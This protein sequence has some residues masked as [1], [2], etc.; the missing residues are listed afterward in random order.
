VGWFLIWKIWQLSDRRVFTE[1]LPE[2]Q[3]L[4]LG[5]GGRRRGE[6]KMWETTGRIPGF[7]QELRPK[8]CVTRWA[9]SPPHTESSWTAPRVSCHRDWP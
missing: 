5:G 9:L 8:T 6:R 2:L 3:A 7:L 4:L 1:Q